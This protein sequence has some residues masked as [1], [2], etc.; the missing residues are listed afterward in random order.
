MVLKVPCPLNFGFVHPVVS[1]IEDQLLCIKICE[2][3]V[4]DD[5]YLFFMSSHDL[6]YR[7]RFSYL[8]RDDCLGSP[9]YR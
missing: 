2:F 5:A 1:F 8:V 3:A 7:E 4:L 6:K 9:P